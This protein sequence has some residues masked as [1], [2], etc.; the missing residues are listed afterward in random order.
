ML[1]LQCAFLLALPVSSFAQG[2]TTPPHFSHEGPWAVGAGA[3]VTVTGLSADG[4]DQAPSV[5]GGSAQFKSTASSVTVNFAPSPASAQLKFTL[6]EATTFTANYSTELTVE[7]SADGSTFEPVGVI[8]SQVKEEATR[9]SF[10]LAEGTTHVRF[11]MTA[12][13]NAKLLLDAVKVTTAPE[14]EDFTPNEGGF[15]TQVTIKGSGLSNATKVFFGNVS[16]QFVTNTDIEIVAKV[17]AGA[18]KGKISVEAA[19]GTGESATDFTVYAPV[20]T[21][22]FSPVTGKAGVEVTIDG[23]YF[24]GANAISFNNLPGTIVPNSVSDTQLK[25]ILPLGATSGAITVT[26]PAGAATSLTNFIVDAPTL[27]SPAFTPGTSPALTNLTISGTG[28]SSVTAV[29]FLGDESTASDDAVVVVPAPGTSDT[30]LT[31]QVPATAKSGKLKVT[32]ANGTATTTEVFTFIPVPT[33][34]AI[35]PLSGVAPV[36][37]IKGSKVTITGTNLEGITNVVFADNLPVSVTDATLTDK[38]DGTKSIDVDVPEGAV[39]GPVSVTTP[40]GSAVS[41]QSFLVYQ[42]PAITSFTPSARPGDQITI[43]GENL[44]GESTVTFLGVGGDADDDRLVNVSTVS[45]TELTL[46]VPTNAV[47][48][49]LHIANSAG[50]ATTS[51]LTPDVFTVD[52]TPL[53]LSVSPT[54]QIRAGAV[55][56]TGKNLAGITSVTFHDNQPVSVIGTTVTPGA[57]GSESIEVNVPSGATT[58]LVSVETPEGTA[59]ST[60]ALTIILKPEN[61]A[62]TTTEGRAG[63]R[64]TITGDNFTGVTS[65]TVGGGAVGY[66][67]IN[68]NQ[69]DITLTEAAVTGKVTVFNAAGSTESAASF[70]VLTS[71][72]ITGFSP[73]TAVVGGRI[74]ISGKL[75]GQVTGVAFGASQQVALVAPATNESGQ[76]VVSLPADATT[77]KIKVFGTNGN[78]ESTEDLIVVLQPS[79]A[80]FTPTSGAVGTEVTITGSNFTE[81]TA[82]KFNGIAATAPFTV[83]ADEKTITAFA[84][85]GA[86]SGKITVTNA[87]GTATS[88]NDFVI[89]TPV[90]SSLDKAEGFFGEAVVIT[91]RYFTGATVVTFNGDDAASFVV[92]SDTQIT[93]FPPADAGEGM[94]AVATASGTTDTSAPT[95]KVLSPEITDSYV[96]DP[97]NTI[98]EGYFGTEVTIVGNYFG[99]ASSVKF[100]NVE[101]L[102]F[103]AATD[104]PNTPEVDERTTKLIAQVPRASLNQ[105]IGSI[106]VVTPSGKGTSTEGFKTLAPDTI[107]IALNEGRVGDEVEISGVYFKD[108]TSVIFNGE[109]SPINIS[110]E[111][112][113]APTGTESKSFKVN[114]PAGAASGVVIVAS[115]SGAGSTAASFKVLAPEVLT[116]DPVQGRVALTTVTIS[117]KYFNQATRVN[118]NG[119]VVLPESTDNPKGFKVVNDNTITVEV[120]AGA[121]TGTISVTTPSGTSSSGTFTLLAPVITQI[122]PAEGRKVGETVT[123]TGKYLENLQ[124]ITFS[125]AAPTTFSGT[126]TDAGTDNG[127]NL[128]SFTVEVPA[129][130]NTGAIDVTT[131]SGTG[132]SSSYKIIPVISGFSPA[133]GPFNATITI[134]GTGLGQ[135]SQVTFAGKD[136]A[137]LSAAIASRSNTEVKVVVPSQART[138]VLQL[139]TPGDMAE[140]ATAFEVTSP[141]IEAL[142]PLEG[143]IGSTFT[144]SG[145]NLV[146]VGRIEFSNGASTSQF[147]ENADGTVEVVVPKNAATGNVKIYTLAGPAATSQQ[148]FTVIK[149]EITLSKSSLN[150]FSASSGEESAAQP[151]TLS[152]TNLESAVTITA[153]ARFGQNFVVSLT[154][155]GGYANTLTI[156]A[157]NGT[158]TN[159]PVFVKFIP[160]G[161]DFYSTSISHTATNAVTKSLFV[162]GNSTNSTLPVELIS[163]NAALQKH[164]VLLRWVTASEKNN[165][166]FEVEI[167][168]NGHTGFSKVGQVESKAANSSVT[169]RY[170]FMHALDGKGGI[171]YYRLKQIDLDGSHTYSKVVAVETRGNA[172][173][174][175]VVAPNPLNYNSKVFVSA[176]DR[177]K[178]V[179][180]LH[181]MVGKRLFQKAVELHEG[182]N[183]IQLPVYER[184]PAGTYILTV[185][186]QN[187]RLQVKVIKQ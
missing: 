87:G 42:V 65:V 127:V 130:A 96:S 7:S 6:R 85:V 74:A 139:T 115:T 181:N 100:N 97:S 16:A 174:Q 122:T 37:T 103:T 76:L 116:I 166:R 164:S 52:K 138:G 28:L 29:T 9:Y 126:L 11:R 83:A 155:V 46:T 8:T 56:V 25:A 1:L 38:G 169:N 105:N 134:T 78:A 90:I 183:E 93:A 70:T 81:I 40:G 184:L 124:T 112:Q 128:Q 15:D 129:D 58:G 111:G 143:K 44:S 173:E 47:T 170:E 22:K 156:P 142:A 49:Q 51:A 67:L 26:T 132:S 91:G 144:I 17:P 167:S 160:T 148:T 104:D 108:I 117:G 179:L 161:S 125:E 175:V 60:D 71:P 114:V 30:E 159:V 162:T 35:S 88:A 89:P 140:T 59:T 80:S 110:L 131:P 57:D 4:A 66:E 180:T 36:G 158:L 32:S 154:E 123:I 177:G 31:I 20:L 50:E 165:A 101:A 185:E 171:R 2:G 133:S 18:A 61:I 64:F 147:T 54:A 182:Q 34:T 121:K 152:A 27:A 106:S 118:F 41:S 107:T 19:N 176:N 94:V 53:V 113:V 99:G 168:G 75:L 178:A 14:I 77:G 92:D 45:N 73:A 151:Y 95:F 79:I 62:F 82:V 86:A 63:D 98:D 48:G 141:I 43:T 149:P 84:P 72:L 3:N 163:F 109:A 186:M 5:N 55:T 69:I 39:T 119:A 68:N 13:E 146:D 23:H 10:I 120:P 137:R 135:T 33:I 153:P 157:E 12:Q 150:Q 24:T 136:G 187:Q 145:V 21:T 102:T 172:M